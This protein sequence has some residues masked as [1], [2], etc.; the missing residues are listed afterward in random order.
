MNRNPLR[1]LAA[2][3]LVCV[4]VLTKTYGAAVGAC[5]FVAGGLAIEMLKPSADFSYLRAYTGVTLAEIFIPE[6]YADIQPNDTVETSAF[7][8]SGVAVTNPILQKAAMSG[9]KKVEVPLWDDLDASGEP[10]YSDDTDTEA[11]PDKL[12][13]DS[14][15]A[16]NAYMNKGY[17]AAD[18][19][20]ELSGA[21]PGSG[22]PMT[23][24]KNR[25][26]SYWTRI[27]QSRL[28]AIARGVLNKNVAANGSDM[29]HDISLQTTVGVTADN[30]I[31]ADAVVEAVFTMGDKFDTI[32][33]IAM[34]S[35]VYKNL[36][37]QQLI[38]YVKDAEGKLLY[39]TYLGRRVVVDDGLP[40]IAGT[41][42]GFRYVTVMFG[43]G[44]IGYGQGKPKVPAE[45]DRKP[46]GG[47]GGGL[48]NIWERKTWMI[49]PQGFDWLEA[50]ITAAGGQAPN[51][52]DLRNANNW[53]RVLDR[54]NC[55]MAFLITNG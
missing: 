52:T 34:H 1:M 17:G 54:K 21:T 37:K 20:V 15:D 40:V 25:F 27:F 11:T 14:Y 6:V 42:S 18:L 10:N 44:A 38:E 30:K 16:R 29:V 19:A 45:V 4:L 49:H 3:L 35:V 39:E 28:I 7:A 2:L 55:P 48:E 9:T 5:A 26:G 8:A 24:I 43:A 13:T 53:A 47:R 36:V 12:G 22:E 23:R 51:L 50:S 33:A 32:K 46:A 41:T 31:S